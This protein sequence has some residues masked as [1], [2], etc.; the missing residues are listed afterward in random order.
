MSDERHASES[1][2]ALFDDVERDLE[3]DDSSDDVVTCFFS[4]REVPRTAA[5]QVRLGPG[6][7]VWMLKEFTRSG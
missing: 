1:D 3:D 6:Q 4:G 5:I 7:R 2:H